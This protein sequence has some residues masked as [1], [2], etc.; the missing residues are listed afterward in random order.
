M[1]HFCDTLRIGI[2]SLAETRVEQPAPIQS[3]FSVFLPLAV[4]GVVDFD[5]GG[6][7]ESNVLL[8]KI[9]GFIPLLSAPRRA[10]FCA[11]SA[12][13]KPQTI[14]TTVGIR[15]KVNLPGGVRPN[16]NGIILRIKTEREKEAEE[17]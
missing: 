11:P 9:R 2:H 1:L 16:C 13:N 15:S 5:D 8:A 12:S 14:H 17:K 10:R 6:M 4:A 7:H 3:D